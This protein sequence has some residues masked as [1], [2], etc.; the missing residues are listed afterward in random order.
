MITLTAI[1][2]LLFD[3]FDAHKILII[4]PLR[5]AK[6]TWPTEIEKWQHLKDL[7]YS[8]VVGDRKARKRAIA[9]QA[10][11]YIINRENVQW[12]I[13][14]TSFPFDYDTV[15]ID[16]LSSFK[17][18][19]S[20]RFKSLMKVR[21][22]V[23]RMVGLTGTPSSNGLMD[24]WAEYRLLDMGER[25]GKF[26]GRFRE[27]YFD[28]DKRNQ[29]MVFSYKPKPGAEEAIYDKI[30]DITISMKGTDYLTLPQLVM[31]E[32]AVQLSEKEMKTLDVMKRDLVATIEEDEITAANAAALSNKLLQMANGAVYDDNGSVIQIHDKKLDALEDVIEAANGKPVLIAYWFKHDLE[33]ITK[34]FKA[35]QIKTSDDIK[36]WNKGDIPIALIHPASA[37]HGLNLQAGG[38][39]LVWFG[40]T[41][42]LELYQQTNARLYR[43]GQTDT[44]VIHHL[45][46]K[47]TMDERVMDALNKKNFTQSALID[48]V[49]ANLGV[50]A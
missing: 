42:S 33:K 4:A 34:R 27:V 45:I 15:V 23:K 14:D 1:Q 10:D 11:I 16:E 29:H 44:V 28:P 7:K 6:S 24:L 21:P 31:N 36:A 35:K 2:N 49:K 50:R 9:Q 12:L 47:G 40:L 18:H 20:K 46:S 39:T 43:Q 5:V 8:L 22:K 32:V 19:Q 38:S 25:L 48:A 30:A 41:W 26:I 17:S 3:S 13:E 37:G